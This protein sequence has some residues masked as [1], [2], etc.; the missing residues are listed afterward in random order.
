MV[1]QT[2]LPLQLAEL[3]AQPIQLQ[4]NL[5]H[6]R[7]LIIQLEIKIVHL[8]SDPRGQPPALSK[9]Y[10]TGLADHSRSSV[11]HGSL[12]HADLSG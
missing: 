9:P 7:Q 4:L 8:S 6:A 11:R 3:R 5:R 10:R 12:F 1:S 2:D